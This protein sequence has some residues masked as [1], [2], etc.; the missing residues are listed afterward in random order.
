MDVEVAGM[1]GMDET[2]EI[3]VSLGISSGVSCV[4]AL[5]WLPT[6]SVN[7]EVKDEEEISPWGAVAMGAIDAIQTDAVEASEEIE[8]VARDGRE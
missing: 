8:V 4:I 1:E 2:K 3:G 6:V 7:K 5:P